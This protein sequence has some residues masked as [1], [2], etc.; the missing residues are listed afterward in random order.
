MTEV[1]HDFTEEEV[2]ERKNPA[3]PY[4]GADYGLSHLWNE[5]APGLWVGGTDDSDV[6][7]VPREGRLTM[8]YGMI[9]TDDADITPAEFDA[10]VTMYAWARPVD[11]GVEELRW[12]IMD[13]SE[14]IKQDE[15]IDTI[16]WAWKRWKAGKR[17]LCRCQ[18]GLNRS[19]LIAA[20]VL[21]RDGMD[22]DEAI[23]TV[24][25]GRSRKCLFNT[26]FVH[27]LDVLEEVFR[28]V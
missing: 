12:G 27:Q 1:E 24:R 10:V 19:S 18:A 4:W 17:V 16:E 20:G 3:A 25:N 28:G 21:V 5:I 15:L 26:S 11:W 9:V 14:P 8:S 22:A 13:S 7:S 6:V 23:L 2:A